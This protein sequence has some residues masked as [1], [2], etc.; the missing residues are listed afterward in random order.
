MRDNIQ[1]IVCL[2][3]F[4]MSVEVYIQN[5]IKLKLEH[6]KIDF[7]EDIRDYYLLY[8]SKFYKMLINIG[9][10]KLGTSVFL[11][12]THSCICM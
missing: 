7:I 8:V 6:D 9:H 11:N 1:Y 10:E 2:S 12:S 5:E 3:F 4:E